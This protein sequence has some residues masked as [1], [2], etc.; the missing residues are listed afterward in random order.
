MRIASRLDARV[1]FPVTAITRVAGFP[2]RASGSSSA[3][4]MSLMYQSIK[5][6]SNRLWRNRFWAS[7]ATP[8]VVT[9]YPSCD[10]TL[11]QLSRSVSSSSIIK[12]RMSAVEELVGD[13]ES[14]RT[15][16]RSVGDERVSCVI[17]PGAEVS[18][19]GITPLV[20]Q[21]AG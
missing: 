6:T 12:M 8:I 18:R 7:R 11:A 15:D 21:N 9:L 17:P 19:L 20:V 2:A 1:G 5:T 16:V 3:P 13:G 4:G 14:G 10:R